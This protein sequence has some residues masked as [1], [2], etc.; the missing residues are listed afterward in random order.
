MLIITLGYNIVPFFSQ[1]ISLTVSTFVYMLVLVL[2]FLLLFVYK[3]NK[4]IK[5]YIGL[6]LPFFF[7]ECFRLVTYDN[8][9]IYWLYDIL[10]ICIPVMIGYFLL[11]Y[12]RDIGLSVSNLIVF[13]FIITIITTI[14]GVLRFPSASRFLATGELGTSNERILYSLANIGGYTFVYSVLFLSPL[15]F[16]AFRKKVINPLIFICLLGLLFVFFYTTEYTIAIVLFSVSTVFFLLKK[17]IKVSTIFLFA[18]IGLIILIVLFEVIS[19]ILFFLSKNIS[20]TSISERLEAMAGGKYGLLNS[21]DNRVELYLMSLKFFLT[22]PIEGVAGKGFSVGGHSFFLDFI[23]EFGIL[24][25]FEIIILYAEI[26]IVFIHPFSKCD[27]YAYLVYIFLETI[28]FSIINAEFFV[29]VLT[30]YAPV[31]FLK[32]L[33]KAG[34]TNE[35]IMAL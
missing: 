17:N 6:L 11:Y 24:G 35:S 31:I 21:D 30:L 16:F 18:V 28:L 32:L 26:F 25:L 9:I 7:Y 20:S 23:A 19:D 12:R 5:I 27:G 10:L 14:I 8:S 33:Y 13:F 34:K 3:K 29:I 4:S 22:Y 2:L 15:L 1:V